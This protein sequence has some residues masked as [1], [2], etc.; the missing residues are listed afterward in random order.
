MFIYFVTLAGDFHWKIH[1]DAPAIG[2]L[3]SLLGYF[4]V[5][6]LLYSK[7]NTSPSIEVR[8]AG[9]KDEAS[10]I[11]T[12]CFVFGTTRSQEDADIMIFPD[13]VERLATNL[14]YVSKQ[15]DISRNFV[16]MFR[17]EIDGM[18]SL[19]FPHKNLEV[20]SLLNSYV[21]S[22][23]IVWEDLF[24]ADNE[25]NNKTIPVYETLL[26]DAIHALKGKDYRR[27]LLFA[28]MSIE[29]L[30]STKLDEI[31]AS[32]TRS[33]DFQGNL[34][35][36]EFQ[37]GNSL[38]RKDP[39]FEFLFSKSK[40][41]E[42]LHEVPLYLIG[43]SLF[44][45]KEVLYQKAIKLY[46]TRNKIAHIGESPSGE[47]SYFEMNEKDSL[48][49]INSAIEIMDWFGEKIDFPLPINITLVKMYHPK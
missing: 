8:I 13:Y 14:R 49:A 32:I 16:S 24:I 23:A 19:D 42:R 44:D 39:V 17:I 20:E 47:Q 4:F 34:R 43:K 27:A 5:N 25:L 1:K 2:E 38:I 12:N 29:S 37:K 45:E 3:S 48:V 15:V 21:W 22:T 33:N 7:L 9:I 26:V 31:Y 30:T 36:I 35:I 6:P 46:R 41:S 40:F 28:A 10:I 18:P 11:T